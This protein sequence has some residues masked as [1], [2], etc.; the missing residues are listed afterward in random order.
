M[1]SRLV[2]QIEQ[3]LPLPGQPHS[4]LLQRLFDARR[5]ALRIQDASAKWDN[6]VKPSVALILSNAMRVQCQ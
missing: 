1:L 3:N 5:H 6:L 2:Y 4:S